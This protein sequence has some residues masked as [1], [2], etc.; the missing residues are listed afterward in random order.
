M[1]VCNLDFPRCLI[2]TAHSGPYRSYTAM[3]W[4]F[5]FR[6]RT[7]TNNSVRTDSL[8]CQ[9][10]ISHYGPVWDDRTIA[11]YDDHLEVNAR[12]MLLCMN[13]VMKVMQQQEARK[14]TSRHG[15]ER[16]LGRGVIINVGSVLSQ[17]AIASMLGYT[18]AKHAVMAMTKTAG[19]LTMESF[20]ANRSSN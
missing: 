4:H 18:T 2:P 15:K 3:C 19:E 6:L 16:Q 14:Y 5:R 7:K 12:G 9:R 11:E 17:E 10:G 1:F 20:F 13:A 8:V